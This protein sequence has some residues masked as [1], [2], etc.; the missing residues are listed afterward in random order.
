MSLRNQKLLA[1][2]TALVAVIA[3]A[4]CGTNTTNHTTSSTT[5]SS[6]QTASNNTTGSSASS[7][8]VSLAETGSSLLYPLFNG[9][10]IQ[11]YQSVDPTVQLTAASTGSGA[12]ISQ[13]IA[14]AVEIGASDAY[15]APAQ[16]QQTPDMINIPVAISAQQIMYNLP[17]VKG[18][19]KLSGKVLADIY[20]G[21]ITFWDDAAITSLNPG[22]S[23]PHKGIVPV[24]RSDGSGD[25]FLFTQFLS[26]TSSAWQGGPGYNTSISWPPL[27]TEVGAKGNDGVVSALTSNKYSIGYV[28]ISWLDKATQA[29]LGYAQ[30]Q[31]K[32]GSFVLPTDAN[33]QAAATQGAKNVPANES[34]SLINEPGANSYPIINFEYVIVKKDQASTAKAT[35]LKSFLKWAVDPSKGNGSQYMTPV[36]FLPLPSNVDTLSQAQ[37]NQIS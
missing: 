22:V 19:L 27:S 37:I 25:T 36:H 31:N 16:V 5:G 26:D 1:G 17:G 35:A 18:H 4:G 34:I 28:G 11:A 32:A 7:G 30:L 23:L 21:K 12:G 14:G 33:I 8:N 2:A 20:T 9:Q 15:L 29:G 6:N 13:S 24:R 3:V 10:W